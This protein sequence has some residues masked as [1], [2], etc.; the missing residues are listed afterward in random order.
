MRQ[1]RDR[2]D[3]DRLVAQAWPAPHCDEIGGWRLRYAGGVT[4]RANSVLPLD[5]PGD[6]A[7]AIECAER[8][9]AARDAPTVF[10]IG[11]GAYPGLDGVLA[12]RGYAIVDPTLI[13]VADIP[14]TGLFSDRDHDETVIE[15][16]PS[17]PWLDLWWSVDGR[18]TD[19]SH[20]RLDA[21][22]QILTGVAA[23]YLLLPPRLAVGRGVL[24]G[25]WYGIYCMAV[26]PH[27]R[28]RGLGGTV[29]RA[30]LDHGRKQGARRAYLAVVERNTAARALYERHGFRVTCRYHYRVR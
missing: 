1:W 9:Y 13:M 30:L 11:T 24:Q 6:L 26:A 2:P 17:S 16:S 29:L 25:D 8:F 27:V 15:D 7:A 21:A 19:R 4:K 22:R 18:Y 12:A 28:R 14:G 23:S 20:D 5:D 3:F 10:S